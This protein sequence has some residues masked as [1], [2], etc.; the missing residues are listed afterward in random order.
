M[1]LLFSSAVIEL[2]QVVSF[3]AMVLTCKL[4]E[5]PLSPTS[6]DVVGQFVPFA[7]SWF[8][9]LVRIQSFV[10]LMISFRW[11]SDALSADWNA[12]LASCELLAIFSCKFE[13]CIELRAINVLNNRIISPIMSTAPFCWWRWPKPACVKVRIL[14]LSFCF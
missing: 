2:P 10:L 14:P 4:V 3:S 12:R 13:F 1:V 9:A 11:L 5:M 8:I 7:R 6:T